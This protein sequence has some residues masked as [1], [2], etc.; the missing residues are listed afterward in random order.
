MRIRLAAFPLL[1]AVALLAVATGCPPKPVETTPT[2]APAPVETPPPT[3]APEPKTEVTE[4]FKPEAPVT[5]E[6]VPSIDEINRSG[7]LKT[8]YFGYDSSEID[9][10]ARAALQSNADW[11]KKNAKFVVEIGGHC[12]E[13]GTIEY[14]IA[15][16]NR[17][18]DSVRQYLASLG[19]NPSQLVVVSYGEE[20][21]VDPGHGEESWAKNRRAEFVVVR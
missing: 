17:R 18:G 15:L 8:V 7:V 9:D 10:A 21:P 6:V 2:P 3:P 20:K 14:N 19:V 11:L 1:V 4:P 16:G 12:D 13:R 5:R